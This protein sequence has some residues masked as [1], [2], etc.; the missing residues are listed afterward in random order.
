MISTSKKLKSVLFATITILATSNVNTEVE[1][2][3]SPEVVPVLN[4][5]G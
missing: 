4:K 5:T 1:C 2:T 3:Q